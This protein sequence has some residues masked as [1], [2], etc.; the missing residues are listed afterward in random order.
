MLEDSL[1][2]SRPSAR[3]KKP[4]TLVLSV[5]VHGTLAG[6]LILIPL[7]QSQVLPQVSL[8][9][10]LHPPV[11]ARGVEL[12]KVPRARSGAP[13]AATAAPQLQALT[14]PVAIPSKIA[15]IMD[16]PVSGPVGIL[17]NRGGG[18]GIGFPGGSPFGDPNGTGGPDSGPLAPP[19]PPKEAAPPPPPPEPP[20]T[21]QIRRGGEVVQSNLIHTVQPVYPRLAVITRSQGKVIL[22]AVITREGTIDPSRLRVMQTASPLLTP[23]AVEA[24][25]Q[26]RYRPTLLNGQP[27]EILTTITINF[28]LN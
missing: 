10:P 12:V 26:W 19:K 5:I 13:P 6:A 9:E 25:Q 24:V 16:Q 14:A 15:N 28:T 3:S 18:G 1:F 8:F 21:V 27:V 20:P 11:A 22:E 17:P 2:A 23:A 4:A 7:F